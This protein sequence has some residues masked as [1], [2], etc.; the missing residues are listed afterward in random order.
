MIVRMAEAIVAIVFVLLIAL[1]GTIIL[2]YHMQ[3]KPI[4][5][6]LTE[7]PDC[8]KTVVVDMTYARSDD[9]WVVQT[10]T[11]TETFESLYHG[12]D[13]KECSSFLSIRP[14]G[15]GTH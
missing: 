1:A 13:L 12:K 4:G 8:V 14:S 2:S 6:T 10:C 11:S 7:E 5:T 15:G 9:C 3:D